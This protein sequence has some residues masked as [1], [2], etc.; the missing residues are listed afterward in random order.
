MRN[1]EA[2]HA[3]VA[4]YYGIRFNRI[5]DNCVK[6]PVNAPSTSGYKIAIA[7]G[8]LG[9][10]NEQW[11]NCNT[12]NSLKQ[13]AGKPTSDCL[14]PI[15]LAIS[16]F[17]RANY[18]DDFDA[19]TNGQAFNSSEYHQCLKDA[20]PIVVKFWDEICVLSKRLE[21]SSLTYAEVTDL[22]KDSDLIKNL[23]ANHET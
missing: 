7:A 10:L 11:M 19:F 4:L 12:A 17:C 14:P 8:C 15:K 3:V 13:S 2:A 6:F 22:L 1:H 9:E 5:F 20:W 16:K 23:A 21:Q 18:Q